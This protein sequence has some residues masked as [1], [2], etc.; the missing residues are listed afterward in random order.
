MSDDCKIVHDHLKNLRIDLAIFYA[1]FNLA[2]FSFI[3]VKE[4]FPWKLVGCAW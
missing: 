4:L 1:L 2:Y 3:L